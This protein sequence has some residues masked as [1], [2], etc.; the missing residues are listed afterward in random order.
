MDTFLKGG[1]SKLICFD[2]KDQDMSYLVY[3]STTAP[4]WSRF[5][6]LMTPCNYVHR[7]AGDYGDT[8]TDEC[9]A[10]AEQQFEYLSTSIEAVALFNHQKLDLQKFGSE[11]IVKES[12]FVSMQLDPR[13]PSWFELRS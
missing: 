12:T 1:K 4:S 9:I 10:D 2:W 8:V 5:E 3:G 6:L 13:R 7:Q 11:T